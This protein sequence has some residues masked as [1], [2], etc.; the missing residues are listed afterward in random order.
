VTDFTMRAMVCA[1]ALMAWGAT[2]AQE[3]QVF[4]KGKPY[5]I[6][7]E[8]NAAF[9]PARDERKARHPLGDRNDAG[10]IAAA[11]TAAFLRC[12][13]G[14]AK[15]AGGVIDE[16]NKL[17]NDA[18]YIPI[19]G[20]HKII[21]L[22]EFARGKAIVDLDKH[23]VLTPQCPAGVR[24]VF[25]SYSTKRVLFVTQAVTGITYYGAK[26]ALWTAK[27]SET[28]DLYYAESKPANSFRKLISLPN[29]TVLDVLLPDNTDQF[30]VLSQSVSTELPMP[31][32]DN[33]APGLRMD[34]YLR[35]IDTMG[36]VLDTVEVA[37]SVPDGKAQFARE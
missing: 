33:S 29:E 31:R 14:D 4:S 8:V 10:A 30:W 28:P 3:V 6:S 25:W 26:N 32:G 35:K 5:A 11:H 2:Q 21:L 20:T 27:F 19:A 22:G 24:S 23:A 16:Q 37:R 1:A 18:S 13:V 17:L 34:I 9:A 15:H 36:T 7:D 12:G